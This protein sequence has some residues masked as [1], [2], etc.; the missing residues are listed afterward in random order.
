[1]KCPR[2]HVILSTIPST[3]EEHI[4]SHIEIEY[5]RTFYDIGQSM[6]ENG[7][8]EITLGKP[9]YLQIEGGGHP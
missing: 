3:L 9:K 5:A 2:C 1:M 6:R 4:R 8:K 7:I